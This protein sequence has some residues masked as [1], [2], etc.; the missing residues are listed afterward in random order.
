M[1]VGEHEDVAEVFEE[2]ELD[3]AFVDLGGIVDEPAGDYHLDVVEVDF[4]GEVV[5]LGNE[6]MNGVR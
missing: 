1:K 2:V 4:P 6:G 5:V 3:E